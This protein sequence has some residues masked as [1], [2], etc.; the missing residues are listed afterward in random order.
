MNAPGPYGPLRQ[1]L[2]LGLIRLRQGG[3]EDP[4]VVVDVHIPPRQPTD[5]DD[6]PSHR[7]ARVE[8]PWV[9]E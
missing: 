8:A 7:A 2:Q 9:H 4:L 1:H 6:A 3:A 5:D